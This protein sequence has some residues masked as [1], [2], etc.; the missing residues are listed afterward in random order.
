M[1]V[2]DGAGGTSGVRGLA[3]S[4]QRYDRDRNGTYACRVTF[5]NNHVVIRRWTINFETL[6]REMLNNIQC[7]ALVVDRCRDK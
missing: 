7:G 6:V 5:C 4:M 1:L 2:E 3:N